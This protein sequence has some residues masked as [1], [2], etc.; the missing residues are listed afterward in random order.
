MASFLVIVERAFAISKVVVVGDICRAAIALSV[1]TFGTRHLVTP[2]LLYERILAA[3]ALSNEG[4]GLGL[5]N[6][7]PNRNAFILLDF[8]A[9]FWNVCL[10]VAKPAAGF[11]TL[12]REATELLVDFDRRILRFVVTKRTFL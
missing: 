5:L 1:A 7:V 8:L 12:G 2:V 10:F 4:F 11:P 9:T 3:V 6:L